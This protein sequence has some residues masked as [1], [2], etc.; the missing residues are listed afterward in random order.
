MF[1]GFLREEIFNYQYDRIITNNR[2]MVKF[3]S[4]VKYNGKF[5]QNHDNYAFQ[6]INIENNYEIYKYYGQ[7]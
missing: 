7:K 4:F 5:E 1:V 6:R 3:T 2:G